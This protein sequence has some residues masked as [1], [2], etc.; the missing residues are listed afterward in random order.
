MIGMLITLLVLCLI[1]GL[2]WYL[3]GILPVPQPFKNVILIIM[4]IIAII[5]LLSFVPGVPWSHGAYWNR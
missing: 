2:I 3:I 5:V 1:F 4:V